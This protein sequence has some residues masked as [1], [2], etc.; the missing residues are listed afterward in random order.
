MPDQRRCCILAICCAPLSAEREATLAEY[1]FDV[2]HET[3][4]AENA[5][6]A[7]AQEDLQTEGGG[8]RLLCRAAA[9]KLLAD[10]LIRTA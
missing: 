10:G 6:L 3:A 2:M 8:L 5:T 9:K 1:L 7:M 4:S